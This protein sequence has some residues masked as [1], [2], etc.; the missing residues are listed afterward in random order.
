AEDG[1]LLPPPPRAPR[2]IEIVGDS[3][4]AAFGVDGVGT[5]CPGPEFAAKWENFRESFGY[6]LGEAF[7]A[8]VEGTVYSGKGVV[9]NIDRADPD[10]LPILYPRANPVDDDSASLFDFRTIVP[11]AIVVMMGANDFDVGAPVDEG[12]APV[13]EVTRVYLGFVTGLRALYP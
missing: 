9:Q 1:H 10:T 3:Q 6:L 12:P 5:G 11:D 4:S 2:Q 7:D 13:D 8:D